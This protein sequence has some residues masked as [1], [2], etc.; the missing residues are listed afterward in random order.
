ML[1]LF[2][3]GCR[4][5]TACVTLRKISRKD[6]ELENHWLEHYFLKEGE[7]EFYVRNRQVV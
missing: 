3:C 4:D 1:S 2:C 5:E 6:G 7:K